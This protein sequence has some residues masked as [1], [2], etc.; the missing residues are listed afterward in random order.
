[1]KIS[2]NPGNFK[3]L[4]KFRVEAGDNLLKNHLEKSAKKVFSIIADEARDISNKEQMSGM[5][6]VIM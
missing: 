5:L 2:T 6:I 3:A 4:L 1:M